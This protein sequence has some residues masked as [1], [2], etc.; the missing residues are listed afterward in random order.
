MPAEATQ[1]LRVNPADLP[2]ERVIFGSTASMREIRAKVEDA[3]GNRSPLL[4]QGESGTGKELIGL[5]IHAHSILST[6]PFVKLNCAAMS[7]GL[8]GG[9]L[10]GVEKDILSGTAECKRGALETAEG[11]TLFLDEIGEMDLALQTRLLG[12]L[13]DG[14]FSRVGGREEL[15][16]H[17]RVICAARCDLK[18]AVALNSFRQDLFSSLNSNR[19]QLPPLR[20]RREDIPLICNYLLEKL[21]HIYGKPTLKPS[22]SALEILQQWRWPGNM[23]ELE[24]WIARIVVFGTEEVLGPEFARQLASMSTVSQRKHR[25][26]RLRVG[27]TKRWRRPHG[28]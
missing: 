8:L 19:I 28:G 16:A 4:I 14:R 5:F 21:A 3:L 15:V 26:V 13:R 2:Q 7:N 1:S 20:E 6:G 24:N 25:V 11:G 18:A 12:V 9:E 10:F 17:L 22:E 27:M 23:R